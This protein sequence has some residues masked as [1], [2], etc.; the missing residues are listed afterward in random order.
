[1]CGEAA[2][3][4][5]MIPLLISYGLTEFSVS[6]P[7]VLKV[8]KCIS[9]WTKQKTDKV[10]EKVAELDTEQSVHDYLKTVI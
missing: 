1:M 7:S 9:S 3:D 2:S 5:M 8:R 10:T 6:P 4:P